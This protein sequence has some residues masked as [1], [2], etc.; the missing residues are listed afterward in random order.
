[1]VLVIGPKRCRAAADKSE[2]TGEGQERGMPT[3][4]HHHLASIRENCVW[5]RA[6]GVGRGDDS[7]CCYQRPSSPGLEEMELETSQIERAP[8][9][10]R[11]F[12]QIRPQFENQA[13]FLPYAGSRTAGSVVF[14]MCA[15]SCVVNVLSA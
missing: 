2:E 9:L 4:F 5:T 3:P 14:V 10:V 12:A 1:V 6:E 15:L 8:L 13:S 11:L 7:L